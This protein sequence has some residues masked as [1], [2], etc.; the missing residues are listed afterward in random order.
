MKA[1]LNASEVL[2]AYRHELNGAEEARLALALISTSGLKL[3][4][5]QMLR[6]LKRGGIMRVLVGV[7]MPTYPD[8]IEQLREFQQRF[9]DRFEVKRFQSGE[10]RIFHSKL[11]VFVHAGGKKRAILGSSNLTLGGFG[12]NFEANLVVDDAPG[13]RKLTD[14]FDELFEG[15][16]A[17]PITEGWLESYRRFWRKAKRLDQAQRQNRLKIRQLETEPRESGIPKRIRGLKYAFTGKIHKWPR[18]KRLYPKVEEYGG[19]I[20]RKANSMAG[21]NFLVHGDI[22]G[23]R[24]STLKLK[25]ARRRNIPIITEEE[26][27]GAIKKEKRKRLG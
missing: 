16:R 18:E 1:L 4:K 5:K 15:A 20:A 3:L 2:D 6:L 19:R 17:R 24:K 12:E 14:Y 26:F 21:A 23:E 13:T 9:K 7:D 25:A 10:R 27:F 11:A 22:L 8:A